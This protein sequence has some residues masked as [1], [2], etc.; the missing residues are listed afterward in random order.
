MNVIKLCGGL[1][2]QLFQYAFGRAQMKYGIDVRFNNSWY[3]K[4]TSR[5]YVLDKFAIDLKLEEHRL[6][7]TIHERG[8]DSELLKKD[9]F[10]F[11]GYWQYPAYSK[12]ILPALRKECEVRKEFYIGEFLNVREEIILNP[13]AIAV[14]VRRGDYLTLEGFPVL[15]LKYYLDAMELVKGDY[16]IFSDDMGWCRENFKGVSFI[17]FQEYL[18]FELMRLCQHQICSRSS[19]SWWA[20]HL[21]SNSDKIVIV[22]KQQLECKIRQRIVNKEFEVYDPKEWIKC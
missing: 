2:N 3:R 6:A 22:P 16:Y 13:N 7:K 21:N 14:H 9:G 17:H 12:S 10:N 18:D 8:F 1:G 19:F 20:A 4:V 11:S 5:C 15:S